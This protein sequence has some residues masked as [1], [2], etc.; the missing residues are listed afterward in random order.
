MPKK[1][2]VPNAPTVK[3][4]AWW[5]AIP[6][7]VLLSLSAD[8]DDGPAH[9]S[10]AAAAELD[11]QAVILRSRDATLGIRGVLRLALEAAGHGGRPEIVDDALALAR[12]MQVVD[13]QQ[14][15]FG[16][17]RWRLG[18][19]TVTDE[20]AAEFAL[21]LASLLR[22]EHSEGL[23]KQGLQ[24]LDAMNRDAIHA[25]R[26]HVVKPGYTNIALMKVWNCLA[27]GQ[28]Y[29]PQ[30]EQEGITLWN[31]WFDYTRQSGITEYVSPTYYGVDLDSLALIARH[32]RDQSVREQSAVAL[33]YLWT[34]IAAH[35][36][37]PAQRLSGPHSRDYDYLRGRG[38][39]D[40]HLQQAGWLDRAP[41]TDGAA[42]LPRASRQHLRVF[43]EACRWDPPAPLRAE[44]AA[45]VP[46][47]VVERFGA[48]PWQRATNHVGAT[49]AI[50][51]AGE[52]RGAEDKSLAIHLPG[53]ASTPNVTLVFDGRG[54]AY[55]TI[56]EPQGD[57]GHRKARH[58]KPFLIASQR[59]TKITAAWLFDPSVPR[60]QVQGGGLTELAAHLLVPVAAELWHG[61]TMLEGE[62]TLPSNAVVFL[63]QEQAAV[64]IRFVAPEYSVD[65]AAASRYKPPERLHVHCDGGGR[66]AKRLTA[67]FA[68]Q[69]P[70][71]GAV[72]VLDI[73][74]RESC[75]DTGFA[76]FR[77]EFLDRPDVHAVIDSGTL[78]V[79][80]SLPLEAD[81]DRFRRV[82]CEPLLPAGRLLEVNGRDVGS[83]ALVPEPDAAAR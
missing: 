63:R 41:V 70:V 10:S 35:W 80:G 33:R 72:L 22:L 8:A 67:V 44:L 82:V 45:V 50:G 58:L 74:A 76:R 21:Q 46:R 68:E 17:F 24:T 73:E 64:G 11:S 28:V 7:L 47:F 39:L 43:R 79:T 75:D 37:E 19:A 15:H 55:G 78:R 60:F 48:Q 13:R 14:P 77:A 51:I 54:D 25:V 29:D 83:E 18:D 16:N 81:I 52:C 9:A 6:L 36:F 30:L 38:Y 62:A 59:G 27:L 65:A 40:E 31:E 5:L 42:W 71:A 12:Q 34:S 2:L 66:G 57:E 61:G 23:S 56:K 69:E 49:L 1:S 26:R 20:N 4:T 32:A 3:P 53:D